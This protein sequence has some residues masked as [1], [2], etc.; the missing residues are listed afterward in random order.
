[1]GKLQKAAMVQTPMVEPPFMNMT[2]SM[3]PES[4][5]H[6]P[7]DTI[8]YNEIGGKLNSEGETYLWMTHGIIG[9]GLKRHLGLR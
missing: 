6:T 8:T 3:T 9:I 1:M 5:K 2:S 7:E 4:R